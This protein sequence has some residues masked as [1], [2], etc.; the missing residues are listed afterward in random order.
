MSSM[1]C[2]SKAAWR[3]SALRA[4]VVACAVLVGAC[5]EKLRDVVGPSP[6]L[7]PTFSSIQKEIFETTDL[8]GRASCVGCHTNQGRNPSG[9]LNLFGTPYDA[10]VGV[11]SRGRPD[12]RFV[13]P[14][15]PDASYLV[16]K[17]EGAPGISGTRMPRSGPPYLSAGQ[18]L[19]IRRWI[20]LGARRD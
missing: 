7:Q 4:G 19:V 15:D 3:R 17:L 2:E 18:M 13:V 20:E 8:A 5:D 10:L 6:N 14:G 16:Q 11:P 12:L 9:G 1:S